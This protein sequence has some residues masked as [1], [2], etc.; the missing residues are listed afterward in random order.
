MSSKV[1]LWIHH[2]HRSWPGSLDI[3]I[4]LILLSSIRSSLHILHRIDLNLVFGFLSYKMIQRLWACRTIPFGI[5]FYFPSLW[6]KEINASKGFIWRCPNN[7]SEFCSSR[8]N[9]YILPIFLIELDWSSKMFIELLERFQEFL[10]VGI[11]KFLK[12]R[13][14]NLYF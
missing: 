11:V 8:S 2:S 12:H 10:E 3:W 6:L 4:H 1:W 9:F 7:H 13:I 5:C 14:L